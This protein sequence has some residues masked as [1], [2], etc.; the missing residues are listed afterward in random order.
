MRRRPSAHPP[1]GA[2]R[3]PAQKPQHAT[4]DP[5]RQGELAE[6][7]FLHKAASLGYTVSKPYGDS[8]HYDFI[9]DTG[10]HLLRVQVKSVRVAHRGAYRIC[11]GSGCRSKTP[12]TAAE[13]DFL[14]A[15]IVPF[16][17]WYVIPV[18][19]FSPVKTLKMLPG[20]R[21]RFESFLDAWHLF[22]DKLDSS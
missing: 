12:Y 6:L 19:A 14:V 11:S 5:K 15:C 8:A 18:E 10:R 9:V 22:C 3:V 17:A 21:R 16:D 2:R 13:I 20:S 4:R 1:R 7:A